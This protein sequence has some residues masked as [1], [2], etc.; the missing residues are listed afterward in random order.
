MHSGHFGH[1]MSSSSVSVVVPVF[2]NE[3]HLGDCLRSVLAQRIPG[4][5]VVCVD[6]GSTDGSRRLIEDLA[7]EGLHVRICAHQS[8]LGVGAARNTALERASGKYVVFLDADDMLHP[9]ALPRALAVAMSDDL[10]ILQV[11]YV[12]RIED[13][14]GAA[15]L[16]SR[17]R[18]VK[19]SPSLGDTAVMD[20][21]AFLAHV[22][23]TNIYRPTV[24]SYLF[25]REYLDSGK[26]R[27]AGM[28]YHEDAEFVPRA[29]LPARRIKAAGLVTHVH[30]RRRD[31]L[32]TTGDPRIWLDSLEASVRIAD[33]FSG[34]D[35]DRRI[36]A[37]YESVVRDRLRGVLRW[38]DTNPDLAAERSAVME[39]IERKRL[40]CYLTDDVSA[41][42]R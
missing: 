14:E 21:P 18:P 42:S 10:D 17:N 15:W 6:D 35:V 33:Y 32:M 11:D 36:R 28:R 27:F 29:L 12:D 39:T 2:N 9:G 1:D 7:G 13:E 37:K 16:A 34:R 3:D 38:L 23:E 25:R 41:E 22:I 26:L 30:R 24:W 20:G 31:S 8:N 40:W 19:I 5:E 4:L